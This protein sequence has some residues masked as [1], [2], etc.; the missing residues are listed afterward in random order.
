[1]HAGIEVSDLAA[2]ELGLPM[3]D[4]FVAVAGDRDPVQG[5]HNRSWALVDGVEQRPCGAVLAG[6]PRVDGFAGPAH[7]PPGVQPELLGPVGGLL[8]V[9]IGAHRRVLLVVGAGCGHGRQVTATSRV[10]GSR[11]A[12]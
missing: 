4:A 7:A 8:V 12:T 11:A 10:V 1:M 5:S 2:G 6:Y 9:G 3:Q